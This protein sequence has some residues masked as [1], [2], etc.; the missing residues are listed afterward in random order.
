[1]DVSVGAEDD[2]GS[3]IPGHWECSHTAG[4]E[5]LDG[6]VQTIGVIAIVEVLHHDFP[7]PRKVLQCEGS[8]THRIF[9]IVVNKQW[10]V[11]RHRWTKWRSIKIEVDHDEALPYF[12]TQVGHTPLL[13]VEVFGLFHCWCAE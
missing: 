11:A 5:I 6:V 4:A 10:L 8:G 1:M 13:L 7:V 9:K 2:S 12:N 3:V